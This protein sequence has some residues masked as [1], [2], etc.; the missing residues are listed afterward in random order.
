MSSILGRSLSFPPRIGADGRFAWSQGEDNLRES[1][2]VTLKTEAGERVMLPQFGAGL[3][4]FLFEP[5]EPSTHTRI[6][7]AIAATLARW[8]PRI[9]VEGVEVVADPQDPQAALA[10]I[11]YRLVATSARERITLSVP[12]AAS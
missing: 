7:D 5:N 11:T 9:E 1:I 12:T 8:E 3:G 6:Q 4:R 2:A 10:T